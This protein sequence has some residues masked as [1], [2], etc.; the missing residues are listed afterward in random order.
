MRPPRVRAVLLPADGP[1]VE[2]AG[3]RGDAPEGDLGTHLL[4]P[5]PAA[6]RARLLRELCVRHAL[7]LVDGKIA[8]LTGAAPAASPWLRSFEVLGS[9]G[10]EE[11]PARLR[12]RA[13]S[14][15]R[16]HTRGVAASA[17]DLERAWRSA[18]VRGG[19]GGAVDVFA[20]R[21]RG[22][23]AAVLARRRGAT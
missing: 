1:S 6:V 7:R 9:C 21:L 2:L 13:P 19:G 16:V 11:V 5:D 22:R 17:P 14:E 18:V 23:V 20:T 15:L 10:L 3:D 4:V 8:L 12:E